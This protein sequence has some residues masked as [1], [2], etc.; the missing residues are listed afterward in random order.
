M[1]LVVGVGGITVNTVVGQSKK[2]IL[3]LRV[4]PEAEFQSGDQ[5]QYRDIVE[6]V[7]PFV[8]SKYSTSKHPNRVKI[9][10]LINQICM[11]SVVISGLKAVQS[12]R[13]TRDSNCDS[14]IRSVAAGKTRAH[15]TCA[16]TDANIL[17]Q[18][19]STSTTTFPSLLPRQ[20]RPLRRTNNRTLAISSK[21]LLW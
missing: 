16:H 15:G 1:L 5:N 2:R 12:S 20:R 18:T 9:T 11:I 6:V 10:F 4:S 19:T 17:P 14:V 8:V 13:V 3:F 7:K 21:T